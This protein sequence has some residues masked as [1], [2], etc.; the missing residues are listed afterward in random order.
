[1]MGRSAIPPLS[2]GHSVSWMRPMP[3]MAICGLL[4]IGVKYLIRDRP[5]LLTVKVPPVISGTVSL[6]AR[7]RSARSRRA[8]VRASSDIASLSKMAGA[9][10][11][12]PGSAMATL[13]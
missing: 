5:R 4:R 9:T 2:S 7:A 11:R 8:A 13:R 10:R 12:L 1:M 6:L 3:N